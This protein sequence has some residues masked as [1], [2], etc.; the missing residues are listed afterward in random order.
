MLKAGVAK[1]IINPPI[2]L[3][4]AGWGAQKHILAQGIEAD[5]WSTVMVLSDGKVTTSVVDLDLSSLSREQSD[6]LRTRVAN[7]LSINELYVRVST[8]H[9]HA[10]PLIWTD[11]YEEKKQIRL[12][13]IH[14][15]MEQTVSA[16][17]EA[18][19]SMI[20]VTVGAGS[21]ICLLT[22]NRRQH[23]EDGRIICGVNEEGFTDPT[24][25]VVR[26]DD[27]TGRTVASMVH[28]A[29]H[30]T[31]LGP[32]N[33][34]FSPEYPGITKKVVE[35]IVGGT[36]LFLQ[37]AAGNL[38]PGKEG[39]TDDIEK[40]RRIGKILG[41]EASKALLEISTHGVDESFEGIVES[42]ASLGLWNLKKGKPK[43]DTLHV[44]VRT[45]HLPVKPQIP[46]YDA[47]E[48]AQ[49][50]QRQ[51]EDLQTNEGSEVE[52][53]EATYKLKRALMA[54]D[55]SELYCGVT[56]KEIEVHFIR[57][58]DVV[59]IG[60][61]IEPFSEIGVEIRQKSPF[62]H[63]WFSG[64]TNG[65]VGYLPTHNDYKSGGY[66]VETTPFAKGSS[67]ILVEHILIILQQLWT[68]SF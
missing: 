45:I 41:C 9:T 52:I 1:A 44:I 62:E 21:G 23:A 28:Y 47:K 48:I 64:Y 53:T 65:W 46:L 51:L 38:G 29:M 18:H 42:G 36:C 68:K 50:F 61:P 39:F 11:Y 54:A 7:A 67:E 37:G 63:T 59:L 43:D 2:T 57:I 4:H 34:W 13:Y 25:S 5:F 15:F 22:K 16:A 27:D 24:V 49:G 26:F 10:G 19:N 66:E 30:P 32:S 6:E 58:G 8:S 20:P 55:R 60:A 40:M 14:Y 31:I 12:D 3:P 35:D 56:H 17:M 33:Q